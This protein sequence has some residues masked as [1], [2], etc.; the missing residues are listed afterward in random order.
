M[1][2]DAY[3][4]YDDREPQHASHFPLSQPLFGQPAKP[5]PAQD[6]FLPTQYDENVDDAPYS[7]SEGMQLDSF[8][9]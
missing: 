3:Y 9:E 1:D 6:R 7:R 5:F 4:R 2:D 8:G